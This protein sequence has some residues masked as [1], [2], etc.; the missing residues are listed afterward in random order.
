[1]HSAVVTLAFAAAVSATPTFEQIIT[2][3]AG[4][5]EAFQYPNFINISA[6]GNY[7]GFADNIVGRLDITDTYTGSELFTEYVFG[8]FTTMAEK[9]AKNETILIGYP[10]N[11]TVVSLGIEPP[12]AFASSLALFNW[13]PIGLV[14]VQIDSVLRYDDNGK[15]TQWDGVMRRFA[16]TASTLEPALAASVRAELNIS[17]TDREVLQRRAA[18][19]I[20]AAHTQYCTGANVQYASQNACLDTMINDKTFGEWYQ[21]GE[22]SVICRYIHTGMV[23]YRPAVH[24]PHLSVSGGG[25]C[26]DRSFAV[27]ATTQF[28]LPMIGD[29]SLAALTALAGS[30]LVGRTGGD[31]SLAASTALAGSHRRRR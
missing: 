28:A 16:W 21:I 30:R 24:C 22:D 1:M 10:Q 12:M 13:G 20:C 27:D 4:F 18:I 26:R 15:V 3:V 31:N 9:A 25:M 14:P 8:L 7:T 19:D 23:A 17:G 29:N 5:S 11:Q 2:G 6:S